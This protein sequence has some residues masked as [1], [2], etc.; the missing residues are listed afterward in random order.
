MNI[1]YITKYMHNTISRHRQNLIYCSL[2]LITLVVYLP[3]LKYPFQFDDLR[4]IAN[5][6]QLKFYTFASLFFTNSRWICTLL[7]SFLCQYYDSDIAICRAINI[8][9]HL[10]SGYLIFWLILR[11]TKNT[12]QNKLYLATLTSLLFLL[13]PV[14]TQ[15][16]SY[17]I[18][19]QLEGLA[20]LFILGCLSSFYFYTQA[21]STKS[22]ITN[23][24]I[25]FSLL[26]CATGTKEIAII[27]PVLILL[28][29][30]FWLASG[31]INKLKKRLWVHLILFGIT[32]LIYLYYLKFNFFW[33]LI[34]GK[35]AAYISTG[36]LLSE[37]NDTQIYQYQF[38]IS[39]FK[40]ILHYVWIFCWP[41]QI[42]VEYDWQLCTS[43]WQLDCLVPFI[44]L[45]CSLITICLLLKKDKT[46]P[47]AFGGL[48]FLICVLPRASIIPSA[49]LLV[50]YKTYLASFGLFWIFA[51]LI[52]YIINKFVNCKYLKR[53]K[54]LIIGFLIFLLASLT[55]TRNQ[56][57]KTGI[58]FWQDVIIKAPKKAR[59]FNNYGKYLLD[60]KRYD[61]AI[62]AFKNAIE[63]NNNSKQET[64]YWDPYQNLANAYALNNQLELAIDITQHALKVNPYIFELHNN[65]GVFLLHQKDDIKALKHLELSLKLKPNNSQTLYVLGKYY[66]NHNQLEVAWEYLNLAC[67]YTSTDHLSQVLDLY[68]EACIK[69]QKFSDAI[70][71]LKKLIK[72]NPTNLNY[73]FNL[74]GVYYFTKDYQASKSCYVQILK[75]EP[76]NQAAQNKLDFLKKL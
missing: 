25:L 34:T 48:W 72:N 5:Y 22:K 49:E 26:L 47:I 13:H 40:V 58:S 54:F 27:T 45:N 33:Q 64:F 4:S 23:L 6:A 31:D 59:G 18:Q 20:S 12:S 70:W 61:L 15:T 52:N 1:N 35:Q 56:V 32:F 37:S 51:Y 2:T 7:N 73:L 9:I 30:W 43:F 55:Y 21:P 29:D 67:M 60:D 17:V 57:W 10:L 39:Q 74:G 11:I 24:V 8:G 44:I 41:M 16:I 42:C 63:L 3:S 71:A 53:A 65:L 46:H 66:L 14:Q 50:D 28:T 69:L 75:I 36:N 68:T 76:D 19:G 62:L 38:L